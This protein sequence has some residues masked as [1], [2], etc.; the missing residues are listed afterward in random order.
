[1]SAQIAQR[2]TETLDAAVVDPGAGQLLRSGQLT[3][4]LRHVRFGVVDESGEPAELAPVKPRMVRSTAPKASARWS[5]RPTKSTPTVDTTMQRR[6][7]ELAARAQESE[8]HCAKAD[9]VE[10]EAQFDAHEHLI[11][12][13]AATMERLNQNL[14]QA[15]QQ[16]PRCSQ[17]YG[18]AARGL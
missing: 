3:S 7:A 15:R 12:D 5:T 8:T 16:T 13:L 14:D 4:A 1:M 11:A 18:A 6:R 2:L 9:R 17:T 10:T